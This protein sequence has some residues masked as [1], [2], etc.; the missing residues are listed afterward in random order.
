MSSNVVT[1]LAALAGASLTLVIEMVI[2]RAVGSRSTPPLAVPPESC[3]WNVNVGE[4][5]PLAAG[6]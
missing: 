5:V 6:V 1:V 3:T 4:P 2:T